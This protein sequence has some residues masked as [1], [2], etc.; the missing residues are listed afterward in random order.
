MGTKVGKP[1][2]PKS[3]VVSGERAGGH[4]KSR[5]INIT[6]GALVAR[7]GGTNPD[8]TRTKNPPTTVT[9]FVSKA[10]ETRASRIIAKSPAVQQAKKELAKAPFGTSRAVTVQVPAGRTPPQL[11]EARALPKGVSGPVPIVQKPAHSVT[12]VLK[13]NE[14]GVGTHTMYGA[15]KPG[16]K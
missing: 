4:A 8:G 7:L 12:T 6:D 10:D 2:F 11:K 16:M 14:R 13:R 1:T 5:H 3:S 15:T 9:K